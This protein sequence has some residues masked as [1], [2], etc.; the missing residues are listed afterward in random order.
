MPQKSWT[1]ITIAR[2][3][4][5]KVDTEDRKRLEAM[6]WRVTQGAAGRPRVVTSVRGKNGAYKTVTLGAFLMKPPKGKQ[7]YPRRFMEGLDY[8]KSNLIVCSAKDRQRL[9]PKSR[10]GASS[11]YRGVSFQKKSGKWR[12]AVKVN[13]RSIN[14]G[15]FLTENAAA[16]AYNEGARKH[17]GDLAYQNR[18]GAKTGKRRGD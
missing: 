7:V 12:A 5:V 10:K 2:K 9:L 11:A 1:Y 6:S 4:K 13:G 18:I 17:F 3:I 8:R 15:E 16:L 14:L